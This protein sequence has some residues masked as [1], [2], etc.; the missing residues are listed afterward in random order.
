MYTKTC[1]WMLRKPFPITIKTY[2][3]PIHTSID[4]WVNK[5]N[6]LHSYNG[7]LFSAKKN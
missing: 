4:E 7:L 1:T 5:Q 2:N 3:Q 6:I